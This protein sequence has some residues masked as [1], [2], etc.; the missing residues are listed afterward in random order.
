MQRFRGGLVFKP[1]RLLYHSTQDLR[2][3]KKKKQHRLTQM[4]DDFSALD[5]SLSASRTGSCRVFLIFSLGFEVGGL[6]LRCGVQHSSFGL[7]YDWHVSKL[8]FGCRT[9]SAITA[10]CTSRRMCCPTYVSRSCEH[11]PEGFDLHL[12]HW[13]VYLVH[14]VP[15]P[16]RCR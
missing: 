1:H 5:L 7:V 13:H 9:T 15:P 6:G 16:Q 8:E 2:V 11:Y 12:L 14:E 10:P 4:S 3:M